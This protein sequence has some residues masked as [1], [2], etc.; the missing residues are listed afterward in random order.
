MEEDN[1][2]NRPTRGKK[3]D[4]KFRINKNSKPSRR[5]FNHRKT[6]PSTKCKVKLSSKYKDQLIPSHTDTTAILQCSTRTKPYLIARTTRNI[7][8]KPRSCVKPKL[9]SSPAR[10]KGSISRSNKRP[11]Q[12]RQGRKP[13][14]RPHLAP[15]IPTASPSHFRTDENPDPSTNL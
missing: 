5:G 4:G 12:E 2:H 15:T 1:K 3:I 10:A 8:P 11:Q 7:E 9:Q 6:Q 14:T 13:T